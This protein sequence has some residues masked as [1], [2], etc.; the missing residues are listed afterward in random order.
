MPLAVATMASVNELKT[1]GSEHA[2]LQ[3]LLHLMQR[4]LRMFVDSGANEGS[5]ALLASAHGSRVV[6]IEPQQ[7]CLNLLKAAMNAS[8]LTG[9]MTYNYLLTPCNQSACQHLSMLVPDDQCHPTSSFLPE[10]G[11]VSDVTAPGRA[12]LRRS[13]TRV[14]VGAA[15]LDSIIGAEHKRVDLWHLDVEGS[16]VL[17]LRS[18]SKLFSEQR[19]LRLM[20]ECIPYRW[21]EHGFDLSR[22]LQTTRKILSGWYCLSMCAPYRSFDWSEA[23]ARRVLETIVRHD[24]RTAE[25]RTVCPNVYCVAPELRSEMEK[26]RRTLRLG[27]DPLV[28]IRRDA[29]SSWL[30]SSMMPWPLTSAAGD[31]I[32]RWRS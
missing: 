7:H 21:K 2:V 10:V 30:A 9:I 14:R 24:G 19:I 3:V 12:Q 15:S 17:A 8:Q 23:G 29:S 13:T 18:A 6:A 32:S 31:V 20:L 4:G 16:E 25:Y 5:W 11:R 28:S 27:I 1:G 22:G 26:M